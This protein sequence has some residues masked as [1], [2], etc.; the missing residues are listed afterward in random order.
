MFGY[1]TAMS[2]GDWLAMAGLWAAVLGLVIWVVSRLFPTGRRTE[3]RDLPEQRLPGDTDPR[4][5]WD[6]HDEFV[7]HV[8]RS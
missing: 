3:V 5:S 7:G 4:A 6:A 1:C 8:G 2:T